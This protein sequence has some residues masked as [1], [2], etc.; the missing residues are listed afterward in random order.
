MSNMLSQLLWH[1]QDFSPRLEIA[2]SPGHHESDPTKSRS[3]CEQG[4]MHC[5]MDA[6]RKREEVS[7]EKI[8]QRKNSATSTGGPSAG[9]P[10]GFGATFG[11]SPFC[12]NV[13][14]AGSRDGPCFVPPQCH[15]V[16]KVASRCGEVRLMQRSISTVQLTLDEP[17]LAT[18]LAT[19]LGSESRIH[20]FCYVE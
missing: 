13:G 14:Q 7:T 4:V 12:F 15:P 19:Q 8:S 1:R 11:L 18:K 5:L 2:E 3:S 10:T 16:N 9:D 17:P 20:R 6:L